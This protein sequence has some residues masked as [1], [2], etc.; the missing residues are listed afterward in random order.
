MTSSPTSASANTRRMAGVGR[1]TVSDLRSIV[2]L[3]IVIRLRPSRRSPAGGQGSGS[4]SEAAD[5]PFYAAPFPSRTPPRGG[6]VDRSGWASRPMGT[7]GLILRGR[8]GRPRIVP[9][10]QLNHFRRLGGRVVVGERV[11]KKV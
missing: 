3:V 4:P 11:R 5:A 10:R 8:D 7:P 9:P 6:G 1:G 2:G